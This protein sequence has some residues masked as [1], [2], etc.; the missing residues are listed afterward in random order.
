VAPD[1]RWDGARSPSALV[2]A[3][4]GTGESPEEALDA[5]VRRHL[6]AFGPA[7]A[8]DVAVWIGRRPPEVRAAL[9]RLGPE[10][11]RFEDEAGRPLHDLPD[12][13]RPEPDTPAPVR[14]LPWFDSVLLAYAHR[15]R[16]RILPD[17]YRD[18][19]YVKANLQWLPSIVVD[20]LVA[21]TWSI[22]AGRRAATLSL[23]PFEEPAPATR[24]AMVEEAER[25]VRFARPD[26]PAHEV[27][28]L[29]STR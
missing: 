10:L 11:A 23:R 27:T 17:A 6:R 26:V 28:V 13:P 29:A 3:P 25:L 14:L 22:E 2:A 7:A 24:A 15:H 8:D 12:A 5:A 4:A 19:V 1:G 20:G 16:A 9:D 18:R 21:G